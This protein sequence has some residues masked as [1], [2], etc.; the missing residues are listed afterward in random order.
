MEGLKGLMDTS[1]TITNLFYPG[2]L[3]AIKKILANGDTKLFSEIMVEFVK[4]TYGCSLPQFLKNYILEN[5][6]FGIET[7]YN[8]FITKGLMKEFLGSMAQ[9]FAFDFYDKMENAGLFY[10]GF[11]AP[12]YY[13]KQGLQLI[14]DVNGLNE[15][16]YVMFNEQDVYISRIIAPHSTPK[17]N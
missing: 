2:E 16:A 7:V 13:T 15:I 10:S 6:K 17:Y 8:M 3:D 4:E 14:G 11:L 12:A 5:P 1:D 9:D